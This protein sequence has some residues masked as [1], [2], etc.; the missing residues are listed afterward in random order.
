MEGEAAGDVGETLLSVLGGLSNRPK[1]KA[2]RKRGTREA[3]RRRGGHGAMEEENLLEKSHGNGYPLS[4][5]I[6]LIPY[7]P[8]E[9]YRQW[10]IP[11]AAPV[12]FRQFGPPPTAFYSVFAVS[13][14]YCSSDPN[15]HHFRFF[16]VLL[17]NV[18]P[19]FRQHVIFLIPLIYKLFLSLFI[20]NFQKMEAK[21]RKV[22]SSGSSAGS[23]GRSSS[24]RPPEP[25]VTR[26]QLKS[27]DEVKRI[28][29]LHILKK[30][31]SNRSSVQSFV[32]PKEPPGL[33]PI[34]VELFIKKSM[35]LETEG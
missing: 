33:F 32:A 22:E 24:S 11:G 3:E 26:E 21:K 25:T 34:V 29:A 12:R 20:C 10:E 2:K 30:Q 19:L 8:W 31:L 7:C 13:L 4:N 28:E 15:L 14:C 5:S 27:P 1:G 6:V 16:L 17:R 18:I 23:S 9:T 35:E